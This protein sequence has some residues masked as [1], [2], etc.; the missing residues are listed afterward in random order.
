MKRNTLLMYRKTNASTTRAKTPT[1]IK[2][3][4]CPIW[5]EICAGL[6]GGQ[7][8]GRFDDDKNSLGFLFGT[9]GQFFPKFP[10]LQL[11]TCSSAARIPTSANRDH[12]PKR[13]GRKSCSRVC[14]RAGC[15]QSTADMGNGSPQTNAAKVSR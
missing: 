15:T 10:K 4:N 12:C 14:C 13:N 9:R 11:P 2:P 3:T 1:T 5:A 8:D 6:R 7:P